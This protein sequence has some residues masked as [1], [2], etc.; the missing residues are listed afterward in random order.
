[1]LVFAAFL[2]M[3]VSSCIIMNRA[4][5]K[6]LSEHAEQTIN[7]VQFFISTTLAG[8]AVVINIIADTIQ[9]MLLRGE[10]IESVQ[11]YM[12]ECSSPEFKEKIR[13]FD[14]YSVY[15][16][17]E[18]FN[19]FL[20]GV[21]WVRPEDYAPQER[22]WYL[23]AV[24]AGDNAVLSPV[25][26]SVNR[27]T[28]VIGYARRLSDNENRLLGVISMN[29]PVDFLNRLV[30]D[31][32]IT[33]SNY[34]FIVD[35]QLVII[36]HPNTD[37]VGGLV[38]TYNTDIARFL[39]DVV[40]QGLDISTC[41]YTDYRGTKSILFCRKIDNGWYINF[42]VPEAEYYKDLYNMTVIISVMGLLMACGLSILLLRIDIARNRSDIQ[43]KQKSSFLAVMSHE[44]R[45]PMNAIMGIAEAQLEE[46]D[47]TLSPNVQ[48]AFDRIYYSGGLL[49][50][51]I[52]DLLD[53]SRI[54]T[55]KMDIM[56]NRYEIASLINEVV[57]L[58]KIKFDSKPI[59]FK[60]SVDED[61]PASLIGDDLRI[62][63]ILNNLLSNA[64]KYTWKG[65][66]SLSVTASVPAVAVAGGDEIDV[67]LVFSVSD[68][69]QGVSSHD[70][71]KLFDEYTRF[72]LNANR[73]T[74]GAGLGLSITQDLVKLM[75]GEI[76]VESE[77]E[78]GSTFTVRLPQ[79]IEVIPEQ[80]SFAV[81]GRKV[82][83]NL[84]KL[85]F[86]SVPKQKKSPVLRENMP[87]G[88]VLIVD[89]VEMNLFVAKLL[90]RPYGLKIDTAS[91][92]YE[93]IDR[94]KGGYAYD[95]IFMD[96]MMPKM[97]GVEAVMNIRN[98]GYT[99]PI[100]ALTANAI[101]GQSEYFL[102]NGFDDFISKPIDM[103]A[104]NM[105]LNKYIR[106]RHMEQTEQKLREQGE[107]KVEKRVEDGSVAINMPGL[108]V[109]Q[110]LEA[111]GGDTEDYMS[112]LYS[113]VKNAPE[114]IEKLR[115]VKKENLSDY[116]INV[117]GLKSI[118]AWICA[119]NIRKI[120]A[121]LEVLAKAGDTSG[122]LEQN[123]QFLKDVETF[124]KDLQSLLDK[125]SGNQ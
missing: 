42:A 77:L 27:N 94:I 104:L 8:P 96:H 17:F 112:A 90:M 125:N 115:G 16:Y 87:Y 55:G 28:P 9:G 118:S 98:L 82:V 97:D 45:T 92:G 14:Y 89:D 78:K 33:K 35:E 12:A 124:I 41:R 58:N 30:A 106:D 75:H 100:I 56:P 15:G 120:A 69:G 24:D 7:D 60:L 116:A 80:G 21:D 10:S 39:N 122:V 44:I 121:D 72:N 23:T 26:V 22:P 99:P 59:E 70:I 105:V 79:K 64:F 113:F 48:E 102:A 25:Y 32:N 109:E 5:N 49:L 43:N 57:H 83:D 6:K 52:S 34:G 19:A 86:S 63:Q 54:E 40:K 47:E 67:I 81:L 95:M 20:D 62:K 66:V 85:Q 117:H 88:S 2:V 114:V 119:E 18:V 76:I 11:A 65:E 107:R 36:A 84:Y 51:I 71:K 4:L 31:K 38:E 46:N 91:S 110:G 50:Q 53:L 111:F 74:I 123:E 29:V 93:A 61:I 73:T 1:V 103:R 101:T 68:T 13:T 3:I 37:V 108:N